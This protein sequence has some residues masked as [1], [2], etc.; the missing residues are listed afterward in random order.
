MPRQKYGAAPIER[1]ERRGRRGNEGR[2]FSPA[3]PTSTGSF[4]ILMKKRKT[5]PRL[6]AVKAKRAEKFCQKKRPIGRKKME[7]PLKTW[8]T[9]PATRDSREGGGK[10]KNPSIRAKEG[11]MKERGGAPKVQKGC[12]S[13]PQ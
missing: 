10:K 3:F 5:C 1:Q 4:T 11:I 13:P 9:Q 7:V 12:S 2:G 6:K 8:S